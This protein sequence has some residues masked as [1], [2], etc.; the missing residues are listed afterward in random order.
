[1]KMIKRVGSIAL[2]AA[3]VVSLAACGGSSDKKEAS[4]SDTFK[5]G[6]HRVR[7]PEM[8]QFTVHA[9]Q[10]GIQLAAD[11][12]NAAGGINGYQIEYQLRG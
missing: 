1:M 8:Q 4:S 5:I 9:V 10:N 7:Q 2:A 12:I 3:M 11:E 6:G